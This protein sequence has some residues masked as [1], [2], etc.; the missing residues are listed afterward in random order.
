MTSET[1]HA[2]IQRHFEDL[3]LAHPLSEQVALVHEFYLYDRIHAMAADH[4]P[5]LEAGCGPGQ[6]VAWAADRGWD[7]IGVDWS[8]QLMAR[9]QAQVPNA[10]FLVG[11]IR[12]LPLPDASVGSIMSLGAIEHA[13]EGP[14]KALAEFARVLRPGGAGLI[15]V[16]FLGPV[17]RPLWV[18]GRPLRYRP[19]ARR[20]RRKKRGLVPLPADTGTRPGWTADFLPTDDGWSFY[21]YQMDKQTM[22]GLLESGG[23]VI[24]EEFVYAP[25]E[26]LIQTFRTAAGRYTENGPRLTSFGRLLERLLPSG[27]YEHMLGYMVTKPSVE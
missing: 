22:R 6:W 19:I 4:Q 25:E 14:E 18:L 17:R 20:L 13:I 15:T 2:P 10:R 26:G 24:D 8:E 23:F 9:A 16:P 7:A 3:F 11:D 21:Q 12:E 5:L 1:E 27:T